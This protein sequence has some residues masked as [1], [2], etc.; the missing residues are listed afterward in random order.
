MV[1]SSIRLNQVISKV[2]NTL[3]VLYAT[4]GFNFLCSDEIGKEMVWKDRLY[5]TNDGAAMLADNFTEYLNINMDIDF[6]PNS[7]FNKDFLD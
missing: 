7:N 3:K 4:N 6:N 1:R 5:L 2:N